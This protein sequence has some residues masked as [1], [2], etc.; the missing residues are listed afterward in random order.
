MI[1]GKDRHQVLTARFHH[2]DFG[3]LP[4]LICSAA[5][6]GLRGKRLRM[7]QNLVGNFVM[8]EKVDECFVSP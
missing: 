3:M 6:D 1:C 8:A 5:C 2:D 4:P 7:M